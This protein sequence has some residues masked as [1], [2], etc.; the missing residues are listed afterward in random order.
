M[1]CSPASESPGRSR[2]HHPKELLGRLDGETEAVEPRSGGLRDLTLALRGPQRRP[3]LQALLREDLPDH[4]RFED[5]HDDLELPTAVRAMLNIDLNGSHGW[6][7]VASK[8]ALRFWAPPFSQASVSGQHG[9]CSGRVSA[10][11]AMSCPAALVPQLQ[12]EER[13]DGG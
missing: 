7:A 5:E 11:A 2:P 4:R 8:R 10:T 9:A 12:I 1:A 13:G 3:G 6:S